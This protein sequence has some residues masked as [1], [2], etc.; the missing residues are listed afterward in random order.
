MTTRIATSPKAKA[1]AR[2]EP[3]RPPVQRRSRATVEAILTA[4][5]QVFE[6]RGYA[7]GTTNR[8]AEAAGV[9]IGTLYQYFASKEALVVAL[10]EQHIEDTQRRM[11][12]WVGH[13]V[14][15]NHTLQASLEDYVEGML[16]VHVRR[17]RLQHILLEETPL[18]EHVHRLLLAAEHQLARTLSG[19]LRTY[20]EVRHPRLEHAAYVAI[21]T[22]EALT[23]RFAAHPEDRV[24]QQEALKR[25]LVLLFEGYL[26]NPQA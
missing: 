10:L 15:E 19:L 18:P 16:A 3:R 22:I 13:M 24:I 4:A 26:R 25:E 20:P 11:R 2:L 12:E 7:G 14:A 21:H 8:I 5:A 6:E 17:P 1:K 23:H 9:S